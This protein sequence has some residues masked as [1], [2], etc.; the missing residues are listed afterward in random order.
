MISE[1]IWVFRRL[2][3]L[4]EFIA[5]ARK[6][7]KEYIAIL[8]ACCC[9][10]KKRLDIIQEYANQFHGQLMKVWGEFFA[11]NRKLLTVT[12]KRFTF[13]KCFFRTRKFMKFASAWMSTSKF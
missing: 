8:N 9:M 5:I 13:L 3:D 7:S 12:L 2:N 11:V 1:L 6:I 10:K 4:P